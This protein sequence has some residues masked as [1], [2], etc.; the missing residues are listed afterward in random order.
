[1][2]RTELGKLSSYL[3]TT[4]LGLQQLQKTAL[5]LGEQRVPPSLP[6]RAVWARLPEGFLTV[7]LVQGRFCPYCQD[8]HGRSHWE[9]RR[10]G[11]SDAVSHPPAFA[12]CAV[13]WPQGKSCL[14][15]ALSS[16]WSLLFPTTR[17]SLDSTSDQHWEMS[18]VMDR[19]WRAF[20]QGEVKRSPGNPALP[21]RQQKRFLTIT[22]SHMA[23][24]KNLQTTCKTGSD[25]HCLPS[26]HLHTFP[27]PTI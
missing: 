5:G 19:L 17:S 8:W 4:A 11:H 7:P 13:I 25:F 3:G 2:A 12:F 15:R 9:Q 22:I 24:V 18:R 23:V 1:M 20:N 21:G 16:A 27:V 14:G 6:P 26:S 10:R